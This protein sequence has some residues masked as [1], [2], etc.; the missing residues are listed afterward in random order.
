M[1]KSGTGVPERQRG[2]N[3]AMDMPE[4]ETST[5][6]PPAG[7]PAPVMGDKSAGEK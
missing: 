5:T 1:A 6:L 7:P 2:P 4:M 3:E